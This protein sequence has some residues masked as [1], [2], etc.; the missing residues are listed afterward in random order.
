MAQ[1]ALWRREIK[2]LCSV[3][4]YLLGELVPRHSSRCLE[5][6][7]LGDCRIHELVVLGLMFR[8]CD[9]EIAIATVNRRGQLWCAL[10]ICE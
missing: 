6:E 10:V 2:A 3:L 7:T 8:D 1:P 9:N 4:R 5:V